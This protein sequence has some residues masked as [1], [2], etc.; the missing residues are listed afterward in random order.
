MILVYLLEIKRFC[1][2]TRDSCFLPYSILFSVITHWPPQN[3]NVKFYC[4]KQ[5]VLL[6][7]W[8]LLVNSGSSVSVQSNVSQWKLKEGA[9]DLLFSWCY[10]DIVLIKFHGN[11]MTGVY[12]FIF[13]HHIENRF[14]F[15]KRRY[16]SKA[17]NSFPQYN[18]TINIA[19]TA[20]CSS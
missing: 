4:Y 11:A 2:Q 6:L 3:V 14:H 5:L 18:W 16:L 12:C 8:I 1:R 9:V 10:L 17:D 15:T 7:Y 13:F 20:R 19:S